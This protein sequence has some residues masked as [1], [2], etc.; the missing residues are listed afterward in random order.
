MFGYGASEKGVGYG[1]ANDQASLGGL[2]GYNLGLAGGAVT[3]ALYIPSW[4]QIGWMWGGAGVG[5][6]VSLPVFLFYTGDDGPPA[7]RAFMFM[8]VT[9]TLGIAAGAIF[10]SGEVDE[11]E[12]G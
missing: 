1:V 10:G 11:Y 12:V 2:I 3:S 9:T 8:G 6:A 7:K 4:E 5:V